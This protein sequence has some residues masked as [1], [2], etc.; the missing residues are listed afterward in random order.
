M[1]VFAVAADVAMGIFLGIFLYAAMTR[2]W[3]GV[4]HAGLAAVVILALVGAH[5]RVVGERRFPVDGRAVTC[6]A[7]SGDRLT[8]VVEDEFGKID[9]NTVNPNLLGALL[10]GL[11]VEASRTE[12]LIDAI[13]DIRDADNERRPYGAEAAEY[14]AA[15]RTYRP[16]NMALDVA[17]ELQHV[18][19]VDADLFTRMRPFLPVFSG[20]TGLDPVVAPRELLTLLS[21][22]YPPTE[23]IEIDTEPSHEA[24][25]EP[26]RPRLK[27]PPG[28][29][30]ASNQR[31]YTVRAVAMTPGGAVFVREAL[32]ELPSEGFGTGPYVLRRW[33]RGALP[34]SGL[35]AE[36]TEGEGFP[37]C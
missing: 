35:Q 21:A 25:P 5:T 16:K 30:T 26:A 4:T 33:R 18:L 23:T 32:V 29:M 10:K 28:A 27:L 20:Q 1:R 15:G 22:E 6:S 24:S 11:G 36:P 13:I 9:I 12:A 34:T 14:S 3:P 7:E 31:L 19:G 37:P 2:L 8:V 17:E